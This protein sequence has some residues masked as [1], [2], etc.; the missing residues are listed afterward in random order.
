[1]QQDDRRL[2]EAFHDAYKDIKAPEALKEETLKRML[3]EEDT[4]KKQGK[5]QKS[6]RPPWYY[7]MAAAALC[8][9]VLAV[10]LLRPAGIS[11]VTMMEDDVFYEEVELKDGLI[12][13]LPNR[14]VISVSPNAGQAGFPE[15][16][17][18]EGADEREKAPEDQEEA[19]SGGKLQFFKTDT[20]KMP[21]IAEEDWSYIGS[22]KIYVSVLE[23]DGVRY[24][25]VFEKED[26]GY[27]VIG[28]NVTQK[29][30]IDYLYK[31]IK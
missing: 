14:V 22:Q 6:K 20:L 24:H 21:P 30:F 17:V 5:R 12:R 29:E 10:G 27:E 4:L 26:G 11:Y 7:G 16:T 18:S 31:K 9:L 25:A 15:G 13:F 28:E 2:N 1:M 3:A 19:K 8:V 23:T